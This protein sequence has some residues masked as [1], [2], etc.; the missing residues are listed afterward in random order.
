MANVKV[1]W[2]LPSTRES[3][4]PLAAAD[5]KHVDVQMSADQGANFVSLHH[6]IPPVL[7]LMVTDLEPGTYQFK[8][9]AVDTKDRVGKPGTAQITIDDSTPP[10]AVLDLVVKLV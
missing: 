2:K 10:G 3:G 6:V 9:F 8:A 5:V 1:S 7:E 4:K